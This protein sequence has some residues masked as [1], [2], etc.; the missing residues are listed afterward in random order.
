VKVNLPAEVGVDTNED[1]SVVGLDVVDN[2]RA[3]DGVLA[4]T[5]C[6]VELAEVHNGCAWL[7]GV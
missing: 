2:H 5:T 3:S 6:A 1:L 4:V 7:V